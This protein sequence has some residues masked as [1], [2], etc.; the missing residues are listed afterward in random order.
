MPNVWM[1]NCRIER[2]V[3]L[4]DGEELD[5]N[6]GGRADQDLTLAGFFSVVDGVER[7]VEN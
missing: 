3:L 4:H 7:I 2:T 5:D 1:K 6:L